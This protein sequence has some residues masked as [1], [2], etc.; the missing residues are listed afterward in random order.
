MK[1]HRKIINRKIIERQTKWRS[2]KVWPIL[3]S[4]T[5]GSSQIL[6]ITAQ[7]PPKEI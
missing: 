1:I 2:N 5:P 4:A 6:P 7:S 3:K